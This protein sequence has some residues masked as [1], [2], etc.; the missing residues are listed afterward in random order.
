MC[1]L[2]IIAYATAV[3]AYITWNAK[4]MKEALGRQN[5]FDTVFCEFPIC[6]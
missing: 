4:L 1:S 5:S 6:F 3:H 2:V